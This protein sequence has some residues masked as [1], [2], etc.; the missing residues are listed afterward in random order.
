MDLSNT[1]KATVVGVLGWVL[2]AIVIA[3]AA[4]ATTLPLKCPNRDGSTSNGSAVLTGRL[5]D[6]SAIL[7][8][9]EHVVDERAGNEGLCLELDGMCIQATV[10][11]ANPATDVA[12]LRATSL[13][14]QIPARPLAPQATASGGVNEGFV[15]GRLIRRRFLTSRFIEARR[16]RNAQSRPRFNFDAPSF[17]GMSGGAVVND[18]GFLVSLVS[19]SDHKK[20]SFGPTPDQLRQALIEAG[21]EECGLGII[22]NRIQARIQDRVC[23]TCPQQPSIP[24]QIPTMPV[25]PT[26]P[27]QPPTIPVQP[28]TN[29]I[30]I[31][32]QIPQPIQIQPVQPT[33]IQILPQVIPQ[34]IQQVPTIQPVPT[35]QPPQFTWP[36]PV[37]QPTQPPTQWPFPVPGPPGQPGSQGPQGIPGVPGSQGPPGPAGP[38]GPGVTQQQLQDLG[39]QVAQF[40]LSQIPQNLPPLTF[41]QINEADGSVMKEKQVRLGEVIDFVYK[42]SGDITLKE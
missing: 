8:T 35:Y 7:F 10:H 17:G 3:C 33:P 12:V 1:T 41:R 40:V 22:R 24:I 23:P 26:M 13:S 9:A 30:Q 29:P 25:Q 14:D 19:T 28:P 31:P 16:S 39:N 11:H 34:I 18:E 42:P 20:D 5:S 4:D 15:N 2:L 36:F 37:P 32:I 38:P 21:A 27:I 6:G